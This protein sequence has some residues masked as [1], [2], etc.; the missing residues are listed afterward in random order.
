MVPY[1]LRAA[2][3]TEVISTSHAIGQKHHARQLAFVRKQ[4]AA[5]KH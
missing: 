5:I 2:C 3:M 1:E 4:L